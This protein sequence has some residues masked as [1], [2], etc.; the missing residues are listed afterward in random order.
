MVTMTVA[1]VGGVVM[2]VLITTR[3]WNILKDISVM[4]V[5][6]R[7]WSASLEVFLKGSRRQRT[8]N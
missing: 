7:L 6:L 4:M 8:A 2:L 5:R 1:L 3:Q